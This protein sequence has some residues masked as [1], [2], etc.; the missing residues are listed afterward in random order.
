MNSDLIK[1]YDFSKTIPYRENILQVIEYMDKV[2]NM[3]ENLIKE[4]EEKNKKYSSEYKNYMYK[5]NYNKEFSITIF[6]KDAKINNLTSY[7]QLYSGLMSGI[8]KGISKINIKLNMSFNRGNDSLLEEHIHEF[9][10]NIKPYEI[11]LS[12]NSN[13]SDD[14]ANEVFNAIFNMMNKMDKVDTIFTE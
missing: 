2:Y 12:R 8:L 9:K 14:E 4:D 3:L 7:E 6:Y 5:K 11:T 10:L 1:E 13:V